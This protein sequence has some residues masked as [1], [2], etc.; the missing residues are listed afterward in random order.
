MNAAVPAAPV[1]T[2]IFEVSTLY[3]LATVRAALDQGLFEQ[4]GG[5]GLRVLLLTNNSAAPE[6]AAPL[7]EAPGFAELA[8]P[9]DR[10]VS[11]NAAIAPLHPSGWRPSDA[12]AP[13]W[14]RYFRLLWDLG[15][16]PVQ[17]IVESIQVSPAQTLALVFPQA[18]IDVYADGLMTWSP[19]RT[20]VVSEIGARIDRLLHLD[21]VPG[22][23]PLLLT[24]FAT[25]R[26]VIDTAAFTAVIDRLAQG[27][28][29][30]QPPA[31]EGPVA[32]L[33]GQ[34][35]SPLGLVSAGEEEQL[36][37]DLLAAAVG[38]GARR[39][40]FKPHPSAP[41]EL[42]GALLER[43]AA[44]GAEVRVFAEP[45]LAEVLYAR[46]RPD[47][48]VGCFSTALATAAELYAIPVIRVGTRPLIRRLKPYP[49]SNRIPL[50]LVDARYPGPD[51]RPG[52]P[53][54]EVAGLVEAVGF[55]MQPLLLAARRP[56]VAAWLAAHGADY[57]DFFPEALLGRLEL[58]GGRRTLTTRAMPL[59]RRAARS[60]YG[61]SKQVEAR[62]GDRLRGA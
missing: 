33:L 12:E 13:L 56:R 16:T 21:L 60:A 26:T 29:L 22:L 36:H 37:A 6:S 24:E 20:R 10:V 41:A 48:V 45:V 14:E 2:Q 54:G 19:T 5:T 51:R 11:Y 53:A 49:N 62:F 18:G 42:T 55:C 32:L 44:L 31:G 47:L 7:T 50:V 34:Y 39:I 57:P 43:A 15:D 8:A 30:P 61:I 17:L 52:A 28:A 58:P 46:A 3:G 59:V 27:Q 40:V 25:P 35:L 4:A 23:D 1:R 38:A 9:F